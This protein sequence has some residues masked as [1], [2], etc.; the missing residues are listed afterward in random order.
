MRKG[1][2]AEIVGKEGTA[3]E[4][5]ERFLQADSLDHFKLLCEKMVYYSPHPPL[6]LLPI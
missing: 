3:L 4:L 1:A 5:A 2:R 6:P